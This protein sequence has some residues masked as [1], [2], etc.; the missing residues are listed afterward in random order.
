MQEVKVDFPKY[1]VNDAFYPL[2]F[3][4][5]RYEMLRGGSGS[6]KSYFAV[7][8]IIY[9]CLREQNNR[10]LFVRAVKDTIRN[11]MYRLFK[12][13]VYALGVDQFFEFRDTFLEITV[14]LTGCEI[15]C[16]GMNDRERLKSI[17]DPTSAWVEEATEL[18][19]QDFLQLNMRLRSEKGG[20]RQTIVT[21]N[22]IDEYH[23]LRTY[24]P[25][26]IEEDLDKKY[27]SRQQRR[28]RNKGWIDFKLDEISSRMIR[29]IKVGNEVAEIDYTLHLS[30]Y[31]DNRFLNLEY[32]AELE[33]LRHKDIN[34]WNIYAKAKWGSVGGLVFNP[35]WKFAEFPKDYDE[36]FY[37]LD[38]GYVHPSV[39]VMVGVKDDKYYVK[40]LAYEKGMTNSAFIKYIKEESLI[41]GGAIIYADSAEPDRIDE[42]VN[43]GFDVYPSMKGNNSVKDGIDMLKSIDIYTC[44]DNYNL[45]RE[46][47]TY[48]HKLDNQGKPIEGE[49]IKV[50]DDCI[51]ATRYAIYTHSKYNEVKVGFISRV[52]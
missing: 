49:Y 6:S 44:K 29:K 5:S 25:D 43:S 51:A 34:Y 30:S 39:L 47:K 37:G 38:F 14:P 3:D 41:E 21:F 23:W 10:F 50:N 36:I 2:L 18:D 32:K 22:P 28:V 20:Y 16:V 45:N 33:D 13:R 26:P 42:W 17:A 24:F 7:D 4:Q 15:I 40:E 8:K 19:E 1:W 12:D 9:R 11:S 46:L 35:M 48:K 52:V 31:E 27:E